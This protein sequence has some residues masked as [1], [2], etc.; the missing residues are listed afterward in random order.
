[1]E[2]NETLKVIANR[3]SVRSYK[4]AQIKDDELNTVL[5][6]GLMAPTGH[7]DQSWYFTVIQNKALLKEISD[8]CKMEM[9]KTGIAWMIGMAKN[10]KLNIFYNAPTSI[11]VSTRK[12]AVT[13]SADAAAAVENML[14]AAESLQ[15]GSCWIGLA[16]FYFNDPQNCRKLDIPDGYEMQYAFILGYKVDG[17]KLVQPPRKY[18]QYFNIIK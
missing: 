3:R 8:C 7:N 15:I 2:M 11:V 18:K 16:K 1:M 9:Q 17:A 13:P 12:D 14:L 10:E 4:D 6:A 5:Q